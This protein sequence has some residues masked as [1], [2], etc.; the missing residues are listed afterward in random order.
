MEL[1]LLRTACGPECSLGALY[2]D[3]RPQCYTLE[4]AVRE[5]EGAPVEDWKIPGCTAIPRGRYRVMRT[6]SARFKRLMPLL[7]NVPGFTGI[8]IHAG[9]TAADT[10]GCILVGLDMGQ[11]AILRSSLAFAA[12]DA[13]IAAAIAAGNEVWMEVR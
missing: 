7:V 3:G 4:N 13:Q 5:V 6:M 1:L 9:N 12:L 2:V 8:R 10:E 11:S